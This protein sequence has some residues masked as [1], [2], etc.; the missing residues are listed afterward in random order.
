MQL[1]PR[2]ELQTCAYHAGALP[3]VPPRAP[4][5]KFTSILLFS[6]RHSQ[7]CVKQPVNGQSKMPFG[8]RM[9][10]YAGQ[11]TI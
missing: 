7:P 6:S 9:L 5:T 10:H 4:G 3:V 2:F 11:F 8:G 1:G